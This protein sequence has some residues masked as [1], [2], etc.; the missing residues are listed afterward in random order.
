MD[1]LKTNKRDEHIVTGNE[2]E[3]VTRS[4]WLGLYETAS[5]THMLIP[6]LKQIISPL[7]ICS[8]LLGAPYL[9]LSWNSLS[10]RVPDSWW[11]G[12]EFESQQKRWENFL[13][14]SWLCVLTLT[15]CL[16]QPHVTRVARKRPKSFCQNCKWQVT[17][18]TQHSQNG[19]T[20]PLSRHRMGTYLETC[21]HAT[22]QGTFS[23]GQLSLLS[24]CGI[25]SGISVCKLIFTLKK[26]KSAS[27]EWM[28]EHS[29]KTLASKEKATRLETNSG[30]HTCSLLLPPSFLPWQFFCI[31]QNRV[32]SSSIYFKDS[33]DKMAY[34]CRKKKK[35]K[36][37]KPSRSETR[38]FWIQAQLNKRTT[39]RAEKNDPQRQ[40]LYTPGHRDGS[41]STQPLPSLL[42]PSGR[43]GREIP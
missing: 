18:L 28:V 22:C 36:R 19:L 32:M 39:K 7:K 35:K 21:S 29:P 30:E 16:F 11:K 15:R 8:S 38:P 2:Y 12:C 20:M 25:K 4:W 34:S 26:K 23:H 42:N 13:L 9:N 14:Q 33:L 5:T 3:I 40:T 1:H 27:R 43:Q 17:P 37:E 24:H 10:V 41:V 31:S 6:L